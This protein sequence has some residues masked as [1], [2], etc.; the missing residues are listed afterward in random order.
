MTQL[1]DD[2]MKD[3]VTCVCNTYALKIEEW[4]RKFSDQNVSV[5][6]ATSV[7]MDISVNVCTNLYKAIQVPMAEATIN[8][9]NLNAKFMWVLFNKVLKIQKDYE[10]EKSKSIN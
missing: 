9:D 5:L 8:Y 6:E 7:I 2:A 1:I 4:L 3:I 10:D